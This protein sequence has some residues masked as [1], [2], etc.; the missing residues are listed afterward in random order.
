M[1]GVQAR[2]DN[3]IREFLLSGEPEAIDDAVFAQAAAATNGYVD[4]ETTYP[5]GDQDTKTLFLKIDGG[6]QQT[7]T[8]AGATTTLQSV[9]NQINEQIVGASAFDNG[10]TQLRIQSDSTGVG[11]SVEIVA[12][13]TTDLSFVTPVAGTGGVEVAL[14]TVVVQDPATSKWYPLTNAAATDGKEI[15]MGV[16]QGTA[17][18]AAA[19]G[20]GDVTGQVVMVGGRV[21]VDEDLLVIQNSLTPETEI[22]NQNMTIRAM[23]RVIGIFLEKVNFITQ[24]ENL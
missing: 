19:L 20:A 2:K 7:I 1:S 8:F 12:G 4:D 21:T 11:S 15:P 13:G 9:I 24:T 3:R 22:T 16:L 10:S 23:L 18:S 14:N 5:V 17:I 6:D